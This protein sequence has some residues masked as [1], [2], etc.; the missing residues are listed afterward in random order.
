MAAWDNEYASGLST[1]TKVESQYAQWPPAAFV[2]SK[3][4]SLSKRL[5]ITPLQLG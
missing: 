1:T 3:Y 2:Q 4:K 5:W